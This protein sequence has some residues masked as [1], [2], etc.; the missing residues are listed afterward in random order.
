MTRMQVQPERALKLLFADGVRPCRG[1]TGDSVL[2]FIAF[3]AT[4]MLT[5][6]G[7]VTARKFVRDR[8]RYV[9]SAQTI[10]GALIAG[11]VAW[12]VA[13]P[14]TWM[15]PLVGA[16]T[17]VLLGLGVGFGVRAGARDIR[18]ERRIAAGG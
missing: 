7:Y 18:V 3:A 11:L 6:F 14:L 8:L 15:L 17:A 5:A 4:L 9:D 2:D 16:G 13:L 10:R 12:A 1:T